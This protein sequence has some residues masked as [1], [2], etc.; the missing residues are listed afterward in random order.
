MSRTIREIYEDIVTSRNTFLN[1]AEYVETPVDASSI[2]SKMSVLNA[3][4]WVT[5]ACINAFETLLDVF[6]VDIVNDLQGRVNGTPAYYANALLK[7]QSGDTLVVDEEKA[8]FSYAEVN[9]TK[10]VITKAA[11]AEIEETGFH[12]RQLILKAATG[13]AGNYQAID[14]SELTQINSYIKQ[15][16]FAGTHVEV[17]SLEGDILVP[18]LTVYYDGLINSTELMDNIR[19]ALD[20]FIKNLDFN[21]WIYYQH[22]IDTIQAVDHV[23]DVDASKDGQGIF[24]RLRGD[25]GTLGEEQAIARRFIPNSGYIKESDDSSVTKKWNETIVLEVETDN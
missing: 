5:A 12:D 15:I 11:Y 17:I 2:T 20:E 21:S 10:R 16:A 14:A 4:S 25:N 24:I 9:E 8:T 6:K 22:I 23:V 7:Y 19:T 18:R 13:S 1:T 3:L